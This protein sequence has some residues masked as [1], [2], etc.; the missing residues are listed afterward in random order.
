[1]PAEPATHSGAGDRGL[2][3]WASLWF[4][5][6]GGLAAWGVAVLAAYP[7]VAAVCDAGASKMWIHAVRWT[8]MVVA[9]A[10]TAVAYRSWRRAQTVG[11]APA[12]AASRARFMGLGGV[13][14]SLAGLFLLLVEDLA[15]WVIDPCW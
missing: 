1:M 10:A 9:L 3:G 7:T 8:A 15:T 11:D 12:R 13:M 5:S 6:L 2:P 14:L 4:G